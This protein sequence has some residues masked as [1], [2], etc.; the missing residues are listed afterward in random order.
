M[1]QKIEIHQEKALQTADRLYEALHNLRYEGK[2]FLKRN[3]RIIQEAVDFFKEE[4]ISY[5]RLDEEVIFPF[6]RVHIPKLEQ[7]LDVLQAENNEF[8]EK[9]A[10]L[11][12]LF[13]QLKSEASDSGRFRKIM[14][15][16][17]DQGTYLFCLVRNHMQ[18]KA[19]AVYKVMDREL[20]QDEKRSLYKNIADFTAG[21]KT[22]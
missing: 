10:E 15:N 2:I 22:T 19:E 21:I 12:G 16:I 20:H 6:L 8:R 1:R 9:L 18:V 14:E 17:C 7:M 13:R 11:E 4:H 5:I 3:I